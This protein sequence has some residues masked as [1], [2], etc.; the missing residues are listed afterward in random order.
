MDEVGQFFG[1]Y[2]V[3]VIDSLGKVLAISGAVTVF[4]S[5]FNK[6]LTHFLIL[7]LD[8]KQ[9][10]ILGSRGEGLFSHSDNLRMLSG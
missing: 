4:V 10:T 2:E 3:V 8:N 6:F 7:Q 5:G 1:S 9:I